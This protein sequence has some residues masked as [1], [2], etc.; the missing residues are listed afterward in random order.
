MPTP[1]YRVHTVIKREPKPD[2]TNND[3]WLNL[4][5]AFP[6]EDGEG[7]NILLQ[8]L[9]TDAKLVLR[10]YKEKDEEQKSCHREG[11]KVPQE[12][13]IGRAARPNFKEPAATSALSYGVVFNV[14]VYQFAF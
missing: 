12:V 14:D 8:A 4:G 3:F 5:V 7:F 10:R 13:A 1:A 2:G 11:Q 9:R 6:H